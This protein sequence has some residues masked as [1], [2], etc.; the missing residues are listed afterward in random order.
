MKLKRREI[1]HSKISVITKHLCKI[2]EINII[3][4]MKKIP[5]ILRDHLKRFKKFNY[6]EVKLADYIAKYGYQAIMIE[7]LQP[8]IEKYENGK[9][10][11]ISDFNPNMLMS[12]YDWNT[13]L[14][15]CI[16]DLIS[17]IEKRIKSAIIFA[18]IIQTDTEIEDLTL[19]IVLAK[20]DKVFQKK[21][22]NIFEKI[23]TANLK[24][25][26]KYSDFI[27]QTKLRT[28]INDLEFGK[29]KNLFSNF[30]NIVK[31]NLI[32]SFFGIF[33]SFIKQNS[34]PTSEYDLPKE[35]VY[36]EK[37]ITLI[38]EQYLNEIVKFR[39]LIAHNMLIYNFTFSLYNIKWK[40]CSSLDFNESF[41][42]LDFI[43][44]NYEKPIKSNITIR[45]FF[46][47]ITAMS[48]FDFLEYAHNTLRLYGIII[49]NYNFTFDKWFGTCLENI[50]KQN[51]DIDI[52]KEDAER[53]L[54]EIDDFY[55]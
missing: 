36:E 16:A 5:E 28:F 53:L 39:N 4:N 55:N 1:F 27:K 34:N 23:I 8:F 19:E 10:V 45:E 7:C 14:V 12:L 30:L 17:Y 6:N 40:M 46:Y 22:K 35:K 2:K 41:E 25:K 9:E 21:Y 38:F 18:F 52:I 13:Y 50:V 20:F 29:I 47:V 11:F 54:G 48:E 15:N 33:V 24:N 42:G 51:F 26:T 43:K 31:Y 32:Q 49:S 3:Y 44:I 37:T